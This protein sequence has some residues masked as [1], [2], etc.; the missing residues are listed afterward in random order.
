MFVPLFV[1]E[2][3]SKIPIFP[4]NEER[5]FIIIIGSS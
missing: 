1:E 4:K 2:A 3:S 5:D